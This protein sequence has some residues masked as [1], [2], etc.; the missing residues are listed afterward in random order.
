M[1]GTVL[2]QTMPTWL[3]LPA[4]SRRYSRLQVMAQRQE[5]RHLFTE[6]FGG[7]KA[8]GEIFPPLSWRNSGVRTHTK[9]TRAFPR[10]AFPPS[11]EPPANPDVRAARGDR[12][13]PTGQHRGAL[14][15]RAARECQ[16]QPDPPAGPAS[17]PTPASSKIRRAPVRGIPP[18]ATPIPK[19]LQSS[20]QGSTPRPRS[21]GTGHP[22]RARRAP[23]THRRRRLLRPPAPQ[24]QQQAA[25]GQAAAPAPRLHRGP[26]GAPGPA[27]RRGHNP[28]GQRGSLQAAH[29]GRP[30]ATA[31]PSA[32]LARFSRLKSS[33]DY[34][35]PPLRGRAVWGTLLLLPPL[36][37][38]TAIPTP[39]PRAPRFCRLQ[40]RAPP[41]PAPHL[42]RAGG[43][44]PD[45]FLQ[46]KSPE[47]VG[48]RGVA[49]SAGSPLRRGGRRARGSPGS[50]SAH[51]APLR[52]DASAG[53][54]QTSCL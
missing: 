25:G 41:L 23:R 10:L 51:P 14:P 8:W 33:R 42:H 35:I 34:S 3:H 9:L 18:S 16:H 46:R 43:W 49:A 22:R 30:D 13:G 5:H 17:P 45:Y 54:V 21:A 11:G 40:E 53:T 32:A 12:S 29:P 27:L 37:E 39:C 15:G 6:F 4:T 26:S 52:C 38:E 48:G 2:Q 19:G 28:A 20:P 7:E 36:G 24:Q 47:W 44:T 1:R 50:V 31:R